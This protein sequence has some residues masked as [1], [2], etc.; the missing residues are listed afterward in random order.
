MFHTIKDITGKRYGKRLV[1]KFA[2]VRDGRAFWVC[3]CLCGRIDIVRGDNLRR[4]KAK[5]CLS[6]SKKGN[7]NGY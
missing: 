4:K 5:Q 7:K 6:C 1:I 3:E 2:Y